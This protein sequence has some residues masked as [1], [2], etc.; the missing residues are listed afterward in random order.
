MAG[1][2]G[3]ITRSARGSQKSVYLSDRFGIWQEGTN[4]HFTSLTTQGFHTTITP[5]DG[6]LY[7]ALMMLYNHGLR[8]RSGK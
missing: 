4:L 6:L 8:S 7:H 2:K 1:A 5:R 3:E